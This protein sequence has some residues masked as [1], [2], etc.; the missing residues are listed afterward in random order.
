MPEVL[1]V[2]RIVLEFI[3]IA[4]SQFTDDARGIVGVK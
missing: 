3:L 1:P 4:F 2:I